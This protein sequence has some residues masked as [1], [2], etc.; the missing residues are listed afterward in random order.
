MILMYLYKAF[1][2]NVINASTQIK[3]IIF[4]R[5]RALLHIKSI[6]TSNEKVF[7]INVIHRLHQTNK[8][9]NTIT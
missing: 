8:D 2:F 7:S 1:Q 6:F 5:Y 4:E 9:K 3:N